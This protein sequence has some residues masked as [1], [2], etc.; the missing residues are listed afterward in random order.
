M[1]NEVII[2]VQN[3][4]KRYKLGQ[5]GSTTLQ[6]RIQSW[7]AERKGKEDP[8]KRIGY[9]DAHISGDVLMALNGV[10]LK[11]YKGESIGIIGK[12]GAGKSTL[13]KLLSRITAPTEGSIDIYGRIASML[14][15][16]TGFD[17]ELTG[18][19]NI[20]LNGA[21][22]GMTNDEIDKKIEEIIDFSEVRD[23]IDTPVKRY[24]SGMYSKLAFSVAAHLDNEIMIMDEVLAV[25]DA[26][27]QE[28]CISAMKDAVS[29]EGRTVL[30]VSHNMNQIRQLCKRCIVLDEGK[31]VFDGDTETAI[32]IYLS[33]KV[34]DGSNLDYH[35]YERPFWLKD[36][37]LRIQ[38]AS[39]INDS[40]EGFDETNIPIIQMRIF[41][42]ANIEN[43]GLR[44]EIRGPNNYRVG[45]YLIDNAFSIKAGET[46]TIFVE[47]PVD[48]LVNENYDTVYT[49]YVTDA[50]GN[51]FNLENVPG[52]SFTRINCPSNDT[53]V[54][55][56]INWGFVSLDG[57]IVKFES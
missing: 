49:F 3:V 15:V 47:Y 21:I 20:Y 43:I 53:I 42:K 44:V 51:N 23:F 35:N 7:W 8:N 37:R 9:S 33:K 46:K 45:I 36:E 11:I 50:F 26:A 27:F 2:D 56:E 25:G 28:K 29:R 55:D 6:H 30:Y 40:C 57:G 38:S 31:V 10:S 18:R 54:W 1:E 22:L 12:N 14:E 5:I 13:L 16:G 39:F 34:V 19:E 52:L 24:S 4:K 17:S 48:N 41:S 32:A